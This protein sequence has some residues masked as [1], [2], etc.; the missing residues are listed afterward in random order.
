M[1]IT[2]TE[3]L[4]LKNEIST[5]VRS[6]EGSARNKIIMGKTIED[7]VVSTEGVGYDFSLVITKLELALIY[8]EEINN[9]LAAFNKENKIDCEVR[10]MQNHKLLHKLFTDLLPQSKPNV[11]NSWITV[12]NERKKVV[13]EYQPLVSSKEIKNKIS[14]HR[15]A[16]REIQVAIEKLNQKELELSFDYPDIEN[17]ILE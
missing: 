8:S 12:H 13:L 10:K 9:K 14:E 11:R 4:R 5:I 16:M 2:I 15:K 1:K 3:A 7:G 6:L 17:L